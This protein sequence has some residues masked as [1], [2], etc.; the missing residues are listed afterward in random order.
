MGLRPDAI[1]GHSAGEFSA[2]LAAGCVEPDDF[3]IEQLFAL[4]H[5][6]QCQEDDR[7]L[8]EVTLLAVAA[9][10]RTAEELL[11]SEA[12]VCIAM[13]NCPHQTVVACPPAA[14]DSVEMRLSEHG[15]VCERLP[16]RRPYH[17]PLFEPFLGPIVQ[18]YERLT[19][20][21]PRL[22]LYSCTTGRLF[23]TEPAAI[24]RL[25]VSHWASP[26]EFVR[27][28]ETMY[29]DGV[30]LFVECGPRGNL[31][32]FLQDILRGKP[33]EAVPVN[34]F[35]R[36]GLTQLNHLAALLAAHHVPLRL[37]HLYNRRDPRRIEWERRP[38]VGWAESSRP[39]SR[40]VVGLEDSAHPTADAP[41][42][43]VLEQY[44]DV[45]EQFLDVEREVMEQFLAH[46]RSATI[47]SPVRPL[48]G[49]ILRHEPG[50]ELVLRRRMDLAEDLYASD[51][52]LGSRHASAMDPTQHGLPFMP[53]AFSLEMMAEAAAVL[54]PGKLVLGFRRVRLQRWIPFDD[55]PTTV[56]LT[57]R[58]RLDA[59]NE[60]VMEIRDFG[61]TVCPGNADSPA[62]TGTV[63][64]GDHY[65]NPPP[66]EDFPLTHET[67]CRYTPHQLYEGEHRLFHGPLFQALVSTDRRGDEGIE[68]KLQTLP[69]SG[70]FRSSSE[71]DLLLDPLLIDASTHLL[72]CWHLGLPDQTG[73]VVL[74]YELGEV[75]IYGPRPAVGTR[76]G[77]RVR[78]ERQSARQVRHRIDLL[79][80]DGRL[81]CRL[82]AAEY[83]RFYWPIEYVDFFRHKDR[84]FLA[85]PWPL[86]GVAAHRGHCTRIEPSDDLCQPVPRGAVAR[87]TLTRSEWSRFRLLKVPENERTQW[88]FGRIAAKD[89]IR[90]LW[91]ERHG[92]RLCPAD[93]ELDADAHGR[94]LP[95]YR[96]EELIAALPSVSFASV[97]GVCAA[98]A[99]FG[100]TPGMAL[101]RLSTVG[102]AESS[103]PTSRGVVGLED[104]AHPTDAAERDLLDGFGQ[105]RAE[106]AVRF[107]CARAAVANALGSALADEPRGVVVRAAD[108]QTGR[109][110]VALGP[111]LLTVYPQFRL[112]LLA[113]DTVREGDLIVATTFCE[114]EC[115]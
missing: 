81:W 6:L 72:G 113:V 103:R 76:I 27:L 35:H 75:T 64:L 115:R 46:P 1:G 14:S 112:D 95:R 88:L 52:T 31:T 90:S 36:S 111:R 50:R 42:A 57:A 34:L 102:W 104:S 61:N 84:F 68:G 19:V 22:P 20:Q 66:A 4:S 30:R 38:V 71:P 92:Q 114:R 83:W 97:P 107:D 25:A 7:Q 110:L 93:I 11:G 40:G 106:W 82:D 59:V 13:D 62:I 70:L 65:P 79:S 2:L 91:Q 55:E 87:V 85:G 49:E 77:C 37:E 44:L 69:H 67:P 28:A 26:V 94:P 80:P 21:P 3:F 9:G 15:I 54:V 10:R 48:L 56:E 29:A 63:I 58:V 43:A 17:T 51:H 78:I 73:R 98:V 101:R 33:C 86:R 45:M 74:P 105:D 8:S 32:A 5:V 100:R 96:G 47:R 99:V 89:A 109:I 18:M 24:R 60:I 41:R 16:F 23:P 12:G 39:T 108:R 53:M